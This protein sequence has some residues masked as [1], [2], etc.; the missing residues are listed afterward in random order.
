MIKRLLLL[1]LACMAALLLTTAYARMAHAQACDAPCIELNDECICD[2]LPVDD[3]YVLL[4][5]AFAETYLGMLEQPGSE[6]EDYG[7][8][9]CVW[10]GGSVSYNGTAYWEQPYQQ[11]AYTVNPP[12]NPRTDWNDLQCSPNSNCEFAGINLINTAPYYTDGVRDRSPTRLGQRYAWGKNTTYADDQ[13]AAQVPPEYLKD[14]RHTYSIQGNQVVP[15]YEP[16][17][18]ACLQ[19]RTR[20]PPPARVMYCLSNDAYCEVQYTQ[21]HEATM[22]FDKAEALC[23]APQTWGVH[24]DCR[25]QCSPATAPTYATTCTCNPVTYSKDVSEVLPFSAGYQACLAKRECEANNGGQAC[26]CL[27]SKPNSPY[28]TQIYGCT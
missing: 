16:L 19:A 3:I 18:G 22:T 1:P 28:D 21:V 17:T 12:P 4:P 27:V 25:C 26:N 20:L 24:P 13:C 9:L 8:G 6:D 7:V 15:E 23:E 10:D 11:A 5:G 2:F 14:T